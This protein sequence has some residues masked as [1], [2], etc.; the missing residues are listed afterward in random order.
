MQGLQPGNLNYPL[1]SGAI[2]FAVNSTAMGRIILLIVLF[3]CL[4]DLRSQTDITQT[5]RGTVTDKN[6][7][8]PLP[9]ANVILVDSDPLTGASAD[10]DGR[11]RIEAVP[12]GRVGLRISYIG[13]KDMFLTGL[14]LESGKELVLRIELEEMAILSE[15]VVI[16]AQTEKTRT[17]NEMTTVSARSFTVEETQRYAGSRNDVAR[18]ASNFAG[19]RGTD[20]SRNDIIIRGNSPSGLLWRLEGVDIPNPNH[21][22]ASESTG[23]PVSILNNNQLAN[24][25][26][27]SGAFPSEYGNAI[28]GV[29]D[30]K[31]RNG[32]NEQH[33]FLGQ[34]G[35]NGFELGAEGPL[36]KKSGASYLV[37]YRYSTLE[38]FH[39]LGL[40][41]GTGT[42]I[43]KYQDFS[44]KV[45]LP[46]TKLGSFSIFGI[47]G[48]SDISI[49]DSEA[50]TSNQ[51]LDFYGGEG[52]DLINSSDLAVLGIT[53]RY[54][55]NS[56]TYTSLTV[57]G[58]YHVFRVQVDSITP[59]DH[60]ILPYFRNS[61]KEQ[62][63]FTNFLVNK[64]INSQHT[65]K[66]GFTL[67]LMHFDFIDSAYFDDYDRFQVLTR[68]NG[69]SQLFQPYVQWQYKISNS[70][71]LNTGLHYQQY[72]L[73]NS[74]SLEPRAGIRW[75]FR[76]GQSVSLAYGYHSQLAPITVYFNK[77]RLE[78]GT[79]ITPNHD[80]DMTH[81][82]HLVLG[83]DWNI[84]TNIRLKSE[85]YYQ[86]ISNAGVDGN[87][88][89]SF[90]IL[91]QGAN[92]YVWTPDT[93]SNDGNGRNY[94]LEFTLEK[95]LSGGMY[96]LFTASLYQSKYSGSDGVERNTAF[97]GNFILNGLMGK[98][99]ILGRK[100]DKKKKR[101]MLFLA[102]LK[103][104]YGGGQRFTPL[105]SDQLG[106][107]NY[108][109]NYDQENAYSEQFDNYFRTD[110]RIALKQNSRKVSMEWA[111]DAQNIFNTKN[112]YSQKFNSS[113][114]EVEYTYQLGLMVIPQFR[115]VF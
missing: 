54:L 20:D 59:D 115:M 30:L 71:T 29:F 98:E 22:G 82:Q 4:H 15:E 7:K 55:V 3:A 9:G 107:N 35:F 33:E 23:G 113:T 63:I 93:L 21:Y 60:I 39:L 12:I 50:D 51:A 95:F 106:P 78:N 92:F 66:G 88:Q 73:N 2:T 85:V 72:Y 61:H 27:M 108:V 94:G 36:S 10:A 77:V 96:Y 17:L 34:I 101:Q 47:G 110:I 99:W 43:P 80:L 103:V 48:L 8:I 46:N 100:P 84:N 112:I 105:E 76:P 81:S 56:T 83:Y 65:L 58:T 57:A 11:F 64:K 14:N 44:F 102:D 62:K 31:M 49:L 114:G 86:R 38:F 75:N 74:R 67:S 111:I 104:T 5:I 97:N 45:N 89:N 6:T 87:R 37:N 68:F 109:A 25:D 28:S 53:H 79:Y 16:R 1:S 52:F 24:S 18:M 19:V 40:E 90:S 91:N 69:P 32:N 26:F 13:Y 41:F 42:A 70:L